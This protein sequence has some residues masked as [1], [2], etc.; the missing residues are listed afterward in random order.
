MQEVRASFVSPQ[1]LE[2]EMTPLNMTP[3]EAERWAYATG[4][5]DRAALL[6]RVAAAEERAEEAEDEYYCV[7]Q[8]L[9]DLRSERDQ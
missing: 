4:D 8:R 9:E 7:R 3:A 6:D 5:T 1:P 2:I